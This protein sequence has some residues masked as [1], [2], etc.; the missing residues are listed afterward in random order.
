MF[1]RYPEAKTNLLLTG[2]REIK[3]G[4]LYVLKKRVHIRSP[5]AVT[6]KD[7]KANVLLLAFVFEVVLASGVATVQYGRARATR[8]CS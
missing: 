6:T 3:E 8:L 7:R 1:L 5:F 4:D 2:A